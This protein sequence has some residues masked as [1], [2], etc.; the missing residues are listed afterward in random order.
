MK[1][2]SL[3]L[4]DSILD[5]IDKQLENYNF[6]TRTEFIREAIRDKLQALE[7]QHF[8][9]EL[10]KHFKKNKNELNAEI[11]EITHDVFKELEKRFG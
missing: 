11:Q 4:G 10:R 3:K 6:S 7:Q 2:V 5:K 8:E 1:T 9:Q